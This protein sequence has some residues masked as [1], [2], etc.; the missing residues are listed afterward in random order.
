LAA[1]SKPSAYSPVRLA[2]GLLDRLRQVAAEHRAAINRAG[3]RGVGWLCLAAL[4]WMGLAQLE[5]FVH[6][7]PQYGRPLVLE[8]EELPDWLRTPE[9]GHIVDELVARLELREE[10]RMLDPALSARLGASLARPEVGWLRRVDQVRIRADGAVSILCQF[11][12]P[13]AWVQAG[14]YCYLVDEHSIRLPGRYRLADCKGGPLMIIVG[15]RGRPPEV[16]QVWASDDLASGLKL[17][18]LMEGRPFRDQI[19][20]VHVANHRGRADKSRPHLE[21][22]TNRGEGRIWWGRPPGEEAGLEITAAQKITLLETLFRQSGRIDMD[23]SYVNIMT[24]PDRVAM[25]LTARVGAGE[26]ALRG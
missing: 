20:E 24:W 5:R 21:L 25:P 9:N 14:R 22:A 15:V 7:L 23:R 3:Y 18:G 4:A 12:R 1:K 10:D 6:A 19:T 17:V 16:G 26:R 8:W 2:R 11:R 13:R